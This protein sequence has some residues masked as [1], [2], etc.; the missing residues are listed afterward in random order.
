MKKYTKLYVQHIQF[1]LAALQMI[2]ALAFCV[3]FFFFI[4]KSA[5]LHFLLSGCIESVLVLNIF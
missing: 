3:K 1:S 5:F 2:L 4:C